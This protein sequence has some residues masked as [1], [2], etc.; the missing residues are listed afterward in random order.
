M[1]FSPRVF[2]DNCTLDLQVPVPGRWDLSMREFH[3]RSEQVLETAV[4][5]ADLLCTE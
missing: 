4:T 1:F 2:V 5:L 3:T